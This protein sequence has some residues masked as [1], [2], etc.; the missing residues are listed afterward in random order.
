MTLVQ[1]NCTTVL[2]ILQ[3]RW[4]VISPA[5]RWRVLTAPVTNWS[6]DVTGSVSAKT[7]R[8]NWDVSR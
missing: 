5:G 8:T 4:S 6:S 2:R 7:G 1:R 3:P